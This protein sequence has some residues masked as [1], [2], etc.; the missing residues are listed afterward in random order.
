MLLQQCDKCHKVPKRNDDNGE[1]V[2]RMLF[3]KDPY[4]PHWGVVIEACQIRRNAANDVD[5]TLERVV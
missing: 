5:T 2:P 1:N 3:G 4:H